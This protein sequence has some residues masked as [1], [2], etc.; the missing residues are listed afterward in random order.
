LQKQ[1]AQKN[2]QLAPHFMRALD[3]GGMQSKVLIILISIMLVSCGSSYSVPRATL[4][5]DVPDANQFNILR[6]SISTFLLAKDFTDLGKDEEMLELLEWSNKKHQGDVVAKSNSGLIDRIHRTIRFKNEEFEVDV[7]IIDY[8]DPAVKKRFVNYSTSE[9]EISDS[10][11]L[12]LNIYNYRPGGFS[13]EAHE[14]YEGLRSFI[15][16][17]HNSPINIVFSPPET[18]QYEFYKSSAINMLTIA[19]WWLIVYMVSIGIFGLIIINILNRTK[20][21][22]DTKRAIFALFGT[23]LAT[24]LPFP[25]ATIFVIVLPSVLALPAIGSDY[26]LRIQAFAVPSFI[27]SAVLCVLISIYS[28]KGSQSENI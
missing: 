12:E 20:L 21:A 6:D 10:P 23:I 2:A 19:L 17:N 14:L 8:S 28:I 27:V 25:A 13:V 7:V 11:T 9:S 1:T 18:D 5:I 22:V 24:P 15:E 16:L 3:V 4:H 26:F